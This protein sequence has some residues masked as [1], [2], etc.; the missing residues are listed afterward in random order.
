MA[1]INSRAKGKGTELKACNILKAA[2]IPARRSQQFCGRNP[3]ASDIITPGFPNIY[4]EIKGVETLGVQKT[5]D[6]CREDCADKDP[7]LIWYKNR[8]PPLVVVELDYFLKLVKCREQY[9]LAET[10][11][12]EAW[13]QLMA[14]KNG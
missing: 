9:E 3:D 5:M 13:A 11:G 7:V 14:A 12:W 1:K 4:W 6:R 2:G 8:K 10:V